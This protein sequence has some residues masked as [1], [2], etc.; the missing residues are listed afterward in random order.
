MREAGIGPM[1]M[2]HD[3]PLTRFL[4]ALLAA[5]DKGGIPRADPTKLADKYGARESDVRALL[6]FHGV[7]V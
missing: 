5:L 6:G 4:I 2:Q 7:G 3:M 1:P